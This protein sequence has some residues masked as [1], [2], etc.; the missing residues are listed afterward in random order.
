MLSSQ[1]QRE[2]LLRVNRA[3]A[4]MAAKGKRAQIDL[5][6]ESAEKEGMR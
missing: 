6:L 4:R 5:R 2:G 3:D 1:G